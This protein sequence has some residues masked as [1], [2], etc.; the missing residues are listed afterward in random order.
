MGEERAERSESVDYCT[1]EG[2]PEN[3]RP[4]GY[5]YRPGGRVRFVEV[6]C[7]GSRVGDDGAGRVVLDDGDGVE[8][9][10]RHRASC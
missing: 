4:G 3:F 1:G 9:G 6:G 7:Y 2:E 10:K 8:G 5:E